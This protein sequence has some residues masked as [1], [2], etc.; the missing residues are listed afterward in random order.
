MNELVVENRYFR[1][2][3]AVEAK[4]FQYLNKFERIIT[5][6]FVSSIWKRTKEFSI[7]FP[8]MERPLK[9]ILGYIFDYNLRVSKL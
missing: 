5:Y 3:S 8:R 7:V 9:K 1:K 2:M 6:G 4:V